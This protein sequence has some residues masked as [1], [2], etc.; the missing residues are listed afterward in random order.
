MV[1]PARV[2]SKLAMLER[3]VVRLRE[4]ADLEE[5]TYVNDHAYEGRYLVQASAQMCIDLANHLIASRGW[6][7]ATEFRQSFERL[8]E[9]GILEGDLVGR[10]KSLTGLRNR[11][12]HLYDDVDDRL[13]HGALEQGLADLDAFARAYARLLAD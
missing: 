2:R 13:V 1:D 8:G 3:Y 12:V 9:H 5:T 7:P 11:L 6:A 4:L 10:L